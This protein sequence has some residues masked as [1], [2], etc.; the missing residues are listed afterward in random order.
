LWCNV[1]HTETDDAGPDLKLVVQD[2]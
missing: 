1:G 2:G